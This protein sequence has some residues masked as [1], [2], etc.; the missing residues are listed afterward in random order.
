[1]L[2]LGILALGIFDLTRPPK[3]QWT[4]RGL[5]LAIDLYQSTL[6]PLMPTMGVHCRF[7][8]TCSHYGEGAIAEYGALVGTAKTAWRILRCGPWSEQGTY[9]PPVPEDGE[10]EGAN[11]PPT[12]G[13]ARD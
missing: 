6:S 2:F 1:M 9:D 12:P 3:S 13:D 8:P 10:S 5:L 7:T 11:E 4:T